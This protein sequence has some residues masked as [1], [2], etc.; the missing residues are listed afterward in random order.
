M[1]VCEGDCAARL[2]VDKYECRGDDDI[3]NRQMKFKEPESPH[4]M[5]AGGI[6]LVYSLGFNPDE[7]GLRQTTT[8]L[9]N[10]LR[11]VS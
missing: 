5:E 3:D 9:G 1:L 8:K 4:C 7:L 11:I 10:V 2:D 6:W